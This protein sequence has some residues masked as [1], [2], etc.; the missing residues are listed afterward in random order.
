MLRSTNDNSFCYVMRLQR[1]REMTLGEICHVVLFGVAFCRYYE[2]IYF[3]AVLKIKI[4]KL[5]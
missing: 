3:L 5:L 1:H 2:Y 4:E